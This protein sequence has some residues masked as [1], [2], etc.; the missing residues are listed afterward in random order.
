M[1]LYLEKINGLE[2]LELK[3]RGDSQSDYSR[4][5]QTA[6]RQAQHINSVVRI[7]PLLFT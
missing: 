7:R 2:F 6:S 5:L 3:R 4:V 1:K